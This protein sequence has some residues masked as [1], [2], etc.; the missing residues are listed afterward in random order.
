MI[1]GMAAVLRKVV[2]I[3][4]DAAKLWDPVDTSCLIFPFQLDFGSSWFLCAFCLC[5]P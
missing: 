2:T 1:L 3:C 4:G 5:V